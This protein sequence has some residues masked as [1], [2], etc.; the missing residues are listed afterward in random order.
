MDIFFLPAPGM[1]WFKLI[2]LAW[3]ILDTQMHFFF[4][5]TTLVKKGLPNGK[6][7]MISNH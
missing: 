1:E 3:D 7:V 5:K 2:G 6:L 4:K